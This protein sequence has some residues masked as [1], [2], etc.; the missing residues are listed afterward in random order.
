MGNSATKRP[1]TAWRWLRR[2]LFFV[3]WLGCVLI[4]LLVLAGAVLWLVVRE[5]A[6]VLNAGAELV[7]PDLGLRVEEVKLLPISQLELRGLTMR[8]GGSNKKTMQIN[9]ITINYSLNKNKI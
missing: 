4:S 6:R 2:V 7:A 5:P 9:Q 3:G 1:K 8:P